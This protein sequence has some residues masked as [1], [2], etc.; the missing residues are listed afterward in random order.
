MQFYRA[1]AMDTYRA[2]AMELRNTYLLSKWQAV[3]C[4]Q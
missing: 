2:Y 3:N 4:S 1:Y